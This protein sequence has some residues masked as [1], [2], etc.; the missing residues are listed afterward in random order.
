MELKIIDGL[1]VVELLLNKHLIPLNEIKLRHSFKKAA[2]VA[3]RCKVL[4]FYQNRLTFFSF[5]ERLKTDFE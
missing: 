1:R 5:R 4:I 3:L 2:P